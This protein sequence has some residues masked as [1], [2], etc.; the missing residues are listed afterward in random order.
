MIDLGFCLDL[1]TS[2]GSQVVK[3]ASEEL[4]SMFQQAGMEPPVNRGGADMLRRHLDCA[5]I[6]F[7]HVSRV[8]AGEAAFD[9]VRAMFP[10][11]RELYANSGF[12]DKTHVQIAVRNQECIHGVFRVHPRYFS[13]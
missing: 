9:T 2:N 10:E 3:A 1:T 8:E 5:V 6:N 13:A 12:K 4:L 7:L 11:G